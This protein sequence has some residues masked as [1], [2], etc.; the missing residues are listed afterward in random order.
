MGATIPTLAGCILLALGCADNTQIGD[1]QPFRIRGGQFVRGELPGKPPA[2]EGMAGS[3]GDSSK[4]SS[5]RR[6]VR[7][8]K[9][10]PR[11]RSS[12]RIARDSGDCD[13]CSRAAA[14][15]K[16]NSSATATK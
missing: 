4:V 3:G 1:G 16:C 15:P 2:N 7:T 10:R 8:N 14:L 6:V 12:S 11:S 13:I 5:T 9:T